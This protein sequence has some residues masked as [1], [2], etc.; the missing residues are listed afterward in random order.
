MMVMV[1]PTAS[2]ADSL[3]QILYVGQLAAR[4]G[5]RK[6]AGELGKLIRS[7]SIAVCLGSLGGARQVGGDLLRDLLIFGWIRLL[8]LLERTQHLAEG[9]KLAAVGLLRR[10]RPADAA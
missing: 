1:V 3:S 7:R 4:R 6:V 5:I 9:R 8:Q 2:A 10:R